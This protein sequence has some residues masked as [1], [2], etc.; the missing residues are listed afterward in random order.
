MLYFSFSNY[1][2]FAARKSN[3]EFITSVMNTLH[4]FKTYKRKEAKAKASERRTFIKE[5]QKRMFTVNGAVTAIRAELTAN[6]A[7]YQRLQIT[8]PKQVSRAHLIVIDEVV[9][10]LKKVTLKREDWELIEV[11]S[12]Q[13]VIKSLEQKVRLCELVEK[14]Y[15]KGNL[16]EEAVK[17]R[18]YVATLIKG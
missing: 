7:N 10:C 16:P 12:V 8:D 15:A 18:Q 11:T 6:A 2:E 4:K 14:A 3:Q 17:T 1:K 5:V 13:Q 9:Y